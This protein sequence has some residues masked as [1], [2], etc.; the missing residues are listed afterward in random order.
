MM[1]KGPCIC[2]KSHI[3]EEKPY[4]SERTIYFHVFG[5][6][7]TPLL[8]LSRCCLQCVRQTVPPLSFVSYAPYQT[9]TH[10][11]LTRCIHTHDMHPAIMCG[12][13]KIL[14]HTAH[15]TAAHLRHFP[16]RSARLLPRG[17]F[18]YCSLGVGNFPPICFHLYMYFPHSFPPRS[19]RLLSR[20]S[21]T[22]CSLG[23]G[24]FPPIPPYVSIC[25]HISHILCQHNRLDYFL[26]ATSHTILLEW[27]F[28]PPHSLRLARLLLRSFS[29]SE[30]LPG[31]K[32]RSGDF[33]TLL[34]IR[35]AY[36]KE[37][38]SLRGPEG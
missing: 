32:R 2:R 33:P 8:L 13:K 28:F 1:T 11:S 7:V 19:A 14:R 30:V 35:V 29:L 3:F 31:W 20:G 23:V 18:T 22:Y 27:F 5:S 34:V 21:F 10:I 6:W 38:V 16:P 4:I 26:E 9:A 25:E 24:N 15:K 37:E 36:P 17:S 12:E